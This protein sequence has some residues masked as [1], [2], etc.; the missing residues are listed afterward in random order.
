MGEIL[1]LNFA[2]KLVGRPTWFPIGNVSDPDSFTSDP[3]PAF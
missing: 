2:A 3:D 1:F